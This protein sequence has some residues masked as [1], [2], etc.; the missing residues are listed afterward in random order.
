MNIRWLKGVVTLAALAGLIW[1][2]SR[3]G[4][5]QVGLRLGQV[6]VTGFSLLCLAGLVEASLDG[7]ALR[8]AASECVGFLTA[9]LINQ[10]GAAVNILIP[11]EA[12]E[13]FKASLLAKHLPS[14]EA[15]S[16]VVVWNMAFR[17]SKSLVILLAA[18][19]AFAFLPS[20]RGAAAWAVGLAVFNLSLYFALNAVLKRRWIG[21]A[22][23]ALKHPYLARFVD[24]IRD[25]EG[26]AAGF[27]GQRPGDYASIVALQAGARA[28]GFTTLWLALRFLGLGYTFPLCL[29]I[30]A[31]TELAT[32]AVALLPTKIGT[33]EGSTYL[34]FEFLK[35]Q[36]PFGAILQVVLRIKQLILVC[37]FLT[38]GLASRLRKNGRGDASPD[39]NAAA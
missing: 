24:H 11:G 26:K 13:I 28:A 27:S 21:R 15:T 37:F 4:W 39:Y 36:G 3:I 1:L 18:C 20:S 14:R 10:E 23:S 35:L 7:A 8:K 29:L 32:Y 6:G 16:S 25:A 30:Y 22:L 2:L 31:L 38:A 34:I 9:L 19:A 5:E 17:L 12:G 33:T